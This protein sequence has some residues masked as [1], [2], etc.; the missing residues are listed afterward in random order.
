MRRRLSLLLLLLLLPWPRAVVAQRDT[1]SV[2]AQH[3]AIERCYAAALD[4]LAYADHSVPLE[5]PAFFEA[6]GEG[7]YESADLLVRRLAPGPTFALHSSDYAP[8]GGVNEG[9]GWSNASGVDLE[10][11]GDHGFLPQ[12]HDVRRDVV[13]G[14]LAHPNAL[15]SG[16]F[17]AVRYEPGAADFAPLGRRC[18]TLVVVPEA[19]L[20]VCER[21]D[22]DVETGPL[23]LGAPL[24]APSSAPI[25]ERSLSQHDLEQS[26]YALGGGL[27]LVRDFDAPG[28]AEVAHRI[29]R[30]SPAA[31]SPSVVAVRPDLDRAGALVDLGHVVGGP[32][33]WFRDALA[34]YAA[35]HGIQAVA[36]WS[37]QGILAIDARSAS[38]HAASA[39][40]SFEPVRARLGFPPL[41]NGDFS[42][43]ITWAGEDGTLLG[44]LEGWQRRLATRDLPVPRAIEFG[45]RVEDARFFVRVVVARATP[46]RVRRFVGLFGRADADAYVEEL[47]RSRA[48]VTF[49]F[50]PGE[51]PRWLASELPVPMEAGLARRLATRD[52]EE[53]ARDARWRRRTERACAHP[54]ASG[55][56]GDFEALLA[57]QEPESGCVALDSFEDSARFER[58]RARAR[59]AC[60]EGDDE[61]AC[62][63]WDSLDDVAIHDAEAVVATCERSGG[64]ICRLLLARSG[65]TAR[66]AA[67]VEADCNHGSPRACRALVSHAQRIGASA[68]ELARRITSACS[69]GDADACAVAAAR[70][71]R[72]CTDATRCDLAAQRMIQACMSN[73]YDACRR[74]RQDTRWVR[75]VG[76]APGGESRLRI[77][78][79][80]GH[81]PD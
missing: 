35:R 11:L 77:H 73:S 62:S 63:L 38:V 29:V 7:A 25:E 41:E 64:A 47:D 31:D 14:V 27:V 8:C 40:T 50:A 67:R 3:A 69:A 51:L 23:D 34:R 68:E 4:D 2:A 18:F 72:A 46:A 22:G 17:P 76:V 19:D 39:T 81:S 66:V 58:V 5:C 36:P 33:V 71:L 6:Y 65:E 16:P 59:A 32:F 28:A 44:P 13:Y 30:V 43:G 54:I 10:R 74:L 45:V 49:V 1:R 42:L 70:E 79:T 52:R 12:A 78:P 75:L 55:L 56:A 37:E 24:P 57:T 15:D 20:W 9:V 21:G 61:D 48:R 60:L 80:R 53:A 26:G